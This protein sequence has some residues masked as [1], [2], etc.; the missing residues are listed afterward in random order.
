MKFTYPLRFLSCRCSKSDKNGLTY[1]IV[2]FLADGR[3]F[4]MF[5]NVSDEC[6]AYISTLDELAPVTG[7][8]EVSY[9]HRDGNIRLKLVDI[10]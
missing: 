6:I 5:A 3:Y 10:Q 9:S 4:E 2:T 1:Y 8:F 7:F